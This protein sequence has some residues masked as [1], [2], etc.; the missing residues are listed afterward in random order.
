MIKHHK[1]AAETQ[2]AWTELQLR[3]RQFPLIR[4]PDDPVES[5]IDASRDRLHRQKSQFHE[6]ADSVEETLACAHKHGRMLQLALRAAGTDPQFPKAADLARRPGEVDRLHQRLRAGD[7]APS[8]PAWYTGGPGQSWTAML[9]TRSAARSQAE[10]LRNPSRQDQLLRPDAEKVPPLP[11]PLE[12]TA[13]APARA[14]TAPFADKGRRARP[15]ER[16]MPRG[17]PRAVRVVFPDPSPPSTRRYLRRPFPPHRRSLSPQGQWMPVR[18][19]W[20]PPVSPG[21]LCF[22]SPRGRLHQPQPGGP[23]LALPAPPQSQ[24]GASPQNQPSASPP[25][26]SRE[27][28]RERGAYDAPDSGMSESAHPSSRSSAS[29]SS[30]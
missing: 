13:S 30:T 21:S 11:R 5:R 18:P 23:P 2:S 22:E 24:P 7:P 17:I 29:G 3:L 6:S 20:G 8:R 10:Q 4:S 19:H 16:W 15:V 27:R 14:Q 9:A 12:R 1:E 28:H 26:S 25:M